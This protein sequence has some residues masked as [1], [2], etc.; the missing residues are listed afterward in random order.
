MYSQKV[1]G[2]RL[3]TQIHDDLFLNENRPEWSEIAT[4]IYKLREYTQLK[5]NI[6]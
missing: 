1:D 5:K 4:I 2:I 6:K 3:T